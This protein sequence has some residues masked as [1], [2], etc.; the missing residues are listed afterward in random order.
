MWQGSVEGP[1]RPWRQ[2]AASALAVVT[3][4][5]RPAVIAE[6]PVFTVPLEPLAPAG[7]LEIWSTGRPVRQG[8]ER[9]AHYSTDGRLLFGQ[10][11]A[12]AAA[13]G[14]LEEATRQCHRQM[15]DLLAVAGTPHLVRVWSWVPAINREEDG[16][17][18][19]QRFC[20][21]RSLAYQEAY[22]RGFSWRLCAATAV[23]SR[24]DSLV[25]HFLAARVAG[26][27]VENP[28]QVPAY[29]YPVQ[30][31]PRSPS[32]AR[33]TVLPRSAGNVVLVAGTAAIVGHASRHPG[34]V[35][36]QLGET[37]KNLGS[38]E[39][40][41]RRRLARDVVP[42]GYRVYLRRPEDLAEVRRELELCWPAAAS[43]LFLQAD[44]CRRELLVEVDGV[45]RVPRQRGR[46]GGA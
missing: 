9:D 39:E 1:D 27:H 3:F 23:G 4:G 11:S 19:Y 28:R 14:E 8:R 21:A 2:R 13:P 44:V 35:A 15:L 18:R 31:G 7:A 26:T 37:R 38:L 43:F 5:R 30:Y 25:M 42:E 40:E 33:A 46:G 10:V 12:A 32:F 16:R 17:E 36:R 45:L 22:G 41:I 6:G 20:R 29:R 24:A 34:Q